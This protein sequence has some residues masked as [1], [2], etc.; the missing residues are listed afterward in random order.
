[1][2]DFVCDAVCDVVCNLVYLLLM[3]LCF[4]FKT[5]ESYSSFDMIIFSIPTILI[6]HIFSFHNQTRLSVL[7][8]SDPFVVTGIFTS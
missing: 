8:T 5:C 2:Y 7:G 4:A 3:L 1:M 6:C